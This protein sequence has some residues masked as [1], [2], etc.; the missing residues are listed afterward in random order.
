MNGAG[1]IRSLYHASWVA[2]VM[3]TVVWEL[4]QALR[5]CESVLDIG[6]GPSSPLQHV[7]NIRRSVGVEA[8]QP[9]LE[10]SKA[11]GIHTEYI[12]SNALQLNFPDKSFDA[13]ILIEVI[14][15]MPEYDGIALLERAERWA[16]KKVIVSTPN[17]FVAQHEVDGNSLQKHL[18]GWTVS[19]MSRRGYRCHGLAGLKWLRQEVSAATMGDD[20]TTSIRF[21]P[22]LFWF[23]MAAASQPL[24]YY[25]P[26]LAFELFCIKQMESLP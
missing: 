7:E 22:R 20:L 8:F 15:H 6:C 3:H 21:R 1:I 12:N 17:G 11:A 4:K 14:E 13:V 24:L 2:R 25:A 16:R 5:D 9:Y 18:S 23:A 19:Q 10:Q 26:R